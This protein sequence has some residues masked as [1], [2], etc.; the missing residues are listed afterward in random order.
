MAPLVAQSRDPTPTPSPQGG[1]KPAEFSARVW[2]NSLGACQC[3][4]PKFAPS[5][6]QGPLAN[7]GFKRGTRI[8]DLLVSL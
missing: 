6:L 7:F 5:M 1:G 8:I 2:I 3:P 4:N